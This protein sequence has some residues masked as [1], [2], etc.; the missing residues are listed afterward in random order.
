MLKAALVDAEAVQSPVLRSVLAQELGR[1]PALEGKTAAEMTARIGATRALLEATG[2]PI[3]DAIPDAVKNPSRMGSETVSKQPIPDATPEGMTD[4]SI[5][6]TGTY[7]PAV[8]TMNDLERG[9]VQEVDARADDVPDARPAPSKITP[10][11]DAPPA[12]VHENAMPPAR[13][14]NHLELADPPPCG[15]CADARR[16]QEAWIADRD[17]KVAAGKA[18]IAAEHDATEQARRAAIDACRYCDDRGM[19]PHG[20]RCGHTEADEVKGPGKAAFEMERAK[21]RE[22]AAAKAKTTAGD[23]KSAT[24][25]QLGKL[26]ILFGEAGVNDRDN[27]LMVIGEAIGRPIAT[28]REL[29]RAEASVLIDRLEHP[30]P[31]EPE[32]EGNP[33]NAE[34]DGPADL[35]AQADD[36]LPPDDPDDA[37]EDQY[38]ADQATWATEDDGPVYSYAG[39]P[40]D[41]PF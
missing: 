19:T 15:R 30:L 3:P 40:D 32:D 31:P 18:A 7:L 23:G 26:A 38:Q 37:V 10:S 1:L 14:R 36:D 11:T 28:T 35:A 22:R 20:V 9:N 4:R 24:G 29:T 33:S 21:L 39:G 13:C 2:K 16:A 8:G 5:T 6:S 27:R 25:D 12:P 17:A 41:P 34:S